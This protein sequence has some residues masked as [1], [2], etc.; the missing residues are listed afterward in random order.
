MRIFVVFVLLIVQAALPADASER[1][2]EK[3]WADE[4]L[5]QLVV[6]DWLKSLPAK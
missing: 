2:R 3:R 4:I 1:A 6:A 5:P